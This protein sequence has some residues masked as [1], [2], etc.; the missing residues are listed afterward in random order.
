MEKQQFLSKRVGIVIGSILFALC[1]LGVT[2]AA[3]LTGQTYNDVN[4]ASQV[5][6]DVSY[7]EDKTM[8]I[9]GILPTPKDIAIKAA[10]SNG[11][12]DKSEKPIPVCSLYEFTVTNTS[13][14]ELDQKVKFYLNIEEN[15]Y[16]NYYYMVFDGEKENISED[17]TPLIDSTHLPNNDLGEKYL[18]P[19]TTELTPNQTKT[20]TIL[21]YINE[22]GENQLYID[23]NKV[24]SASVKVEA[25]TSGTYKPNKPDIENTN[26]VPIK[27]DGNKWVVTSEDDPEWYDYS[28]QKW[29]N[30]ALLKDGV[31]KESGTVLKVPDGDT[32]TE[33]QS[34][35]YAMFVWI[36]RFSYTIGC[37]SSSSCLGYKVEEASALS[38]TTPGA[39]DIKFVS[40]ED[41]P[42]IP[43]MDNGIYP[44]YT[45]TS[46]NNRTPTNWYTHPAFWWDENGDGVRPEDNSEELAGI[47]VGKFETS[48]DSTSKCYSN[49][50]SNNKS[51]STN[52]AASESNV[53]PRILPNV[54]A[55]TYQ[56]VSNQFNTANKFSAENNIYGIDNTKTD[57]HMMKNSEW[58]AVAYLSQS[59]YGK[60]GN[61]NYSGANKEIYINNCSGYYTGI[62]AGVP[63]T[64][65]SS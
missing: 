16:T 46:E 65:S 43:D 17:K 55:L 25:S 58:S 53:T 39:I 4:M 19:L 7:T 35:V 51:A 50:N 49:L 23:T 52:C 14:D 27:Y 54:L 37:T 63:S 12:Y 5:T 22:T 2:Y 8:M 59:I 3:Y 33:S 42:E 21:F 28:K 48:V 44:K 24:F 29:A 47:W 61:K 64:I 6:P 41:K 62:S 45:Y 34:N 20:Y 10:A 56:T 32:I 1:F 26:L 13:L 11:C 40:R 30:A 9:Q 31:S 60:Y 36:P 38:T 57:S 18:F 15:T